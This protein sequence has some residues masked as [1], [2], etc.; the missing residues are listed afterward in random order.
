MVGAVFTISPFDVAVW[1]VYFI[2]IITIMTLSYFEYE[3]NAKCKYSNLIQEE[4]G[5][6]LFVNKESLLLIFIKKVILPLGVVLPSDRQYLYFVIY[7]VFY[8]I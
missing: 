7:I 5:L 2:E 6:S 8:V 4:T 3:S 1:I